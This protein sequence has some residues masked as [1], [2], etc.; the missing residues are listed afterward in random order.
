MSGVR[1]GM[2]RV[3][4]LG[5]LVQSVL[6]LGPVDRVRG[7]ERAA[8]PIGPEADHGQQRQDRRDAGPA[9][10]VVSMSSE[11][12]DSLARLAVLYRTT[13]RAIIAANA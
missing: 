9:P 4:R 5:L 1:R 10:N 11:R 6:L 3:I 12:G 2:R 13:R 8:C 7:P